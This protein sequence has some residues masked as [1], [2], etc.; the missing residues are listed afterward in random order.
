MARVWS[1][2][3][4]ELKLVSLPVGKLGIRSREYWRLDRRY[5]QTLP[6]GQLPSD[7]ML[8]ATQCFAAL[9]DV[10]ESALANAKSD[11]EHRPMLDATAAMIALNDYRYDDSLAFAEA[12]MK[13]DPQY[14]WAMAEIARNCAIHD[15]RWKLAVDLVNQF[16]HCINDA[17]E[18]AGTEQMME[19]A[20][21]EFEQL[22]ADEMPNPV[23][24]FSTLPF[25][26]HKLDFKLFDVDPPDALKQ[27]SQELQKKG[28]L[29][30]NVPDGHYYDLCIGPGAANADLGVT[31]RL[32]ATDKIQSEW[33]KL[34][35]L[36]LLDSQSKKRILGLWIYYNFEVQIR[37]GDQEFL[38]MDLS[39]ELAAKKPFTIRMSAVGNRMEIDLND[40][41]IFY[42]P[43]LAD[44]TA[45]QLAVHA[46]FQGMSGSLADVAWRTAGPGGH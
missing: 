26:S 16:P 2:A 36:E 8:V 35:E 15:F 41:R 37:L 28:K 22:P 32:R 12:A 38:T 43:L 39:K 5:V 17:Q 33:G 7:E 30:F 18:Q 27:F 25:A 20:I 45:R 42:G 40:R 24:A 1:A 23:Q 46:H 34:I 13:E 21:R 3:N 4:K 10:A 6:K 9:P 14:A 29:S 31:C 44:E 11:G 19:D